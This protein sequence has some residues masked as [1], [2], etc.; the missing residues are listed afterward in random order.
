MKTYKHLFWVAAML[1]SVAA[2]HAS[3]NF[4]F[5][6]VQT[7]GTPGGTPAWATMT[8]TNIV[9]GVQITLN[10]LS[11]AP[12]ESSRFISQLNLLFNTNP[13]GFSTLSDPYITNI[14]IG[15]FTD[16]SLSFNVK[17]DFKVA[18]PSARLTQGLSSTFQLFGVSESDF[19]GFDNSAMVHFQALQGGDSSKVIAPEPASLIAL[20]VG[21]AGLMGRRLRKR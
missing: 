10:H 3:L 15:S 9:G 6:T 14:T 16:A 17:V 13:A 20:G 21:L 5:T 7:G 11:T 1:F 8:I 12:S 4:V 18:P 19:A 2:S